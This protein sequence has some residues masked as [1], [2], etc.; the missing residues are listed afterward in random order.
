MLTFPAVF[1]ILLPL[2][3]GILSGRIPRIFQQEK[4]GSVVLISL[5]PH[6]QTKM[7]KNYPRFHF[8]PAYN[9]INDP[10]GTIYFNGS[11]HLFYQY[12][13][14]SDKWGNLHWGHTRTKDFIHYE[15]MKDMLC[16]QH[17]KGEHHC[18]SGCIGINSN[19]NPVLMYTSVQYDE[20]HNPN[21][22]K[23]VLLDKDMKTLSDERINAI[24]VDME[25][26]PSEI[27]HDW[28]D[29][30]MFNADGRFFLVLGAAV[31][32]SQVPSILLFESPDGSLVNWKY[33][34]VLQTFKPI[35]E[36]MECPNFFPLQGKWVLLGSPY[37][38]VQYQTGTFNTEKLEFKTEEAGLIDHSSQFYATNTFR[39]NRNRTILVA[40]INGF[41]SGQGWNNVIS[42]PRTL[43]LTDNREL[44]QLP[45]S[46][47]D[48][49]QGKSLLSGGK[50]KADIMLNGAMQIS[51]PALLQCR[52]TCT[53]IRSEATAEMEVLLK[54]GTREICKISIAPE[55]IV[56][57][58]IHIPSTRQNATEIDLLIDHSV[59]EIF[60]DGGRY[61]ATRT[62]EAIQ[63][64][65]TLEFKGNCL[66]KALQVHE[67][68]SLSIIEEQ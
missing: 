58:S 48:T 37:G 60:I 14:A 22:Q 40:F 41:S 6:H 18:F 61:C 44:V 55:E 11:Y 5:L 21:I 2:Q 17:E 34:K 26:L 68:K 27:R 10:N 59:M 12:N 63:N 28:R 20:K 65:E 35:I 54:A 45:I 57:D 16:P 56:F 29:P 51:D 24:T 67:V 39:D 4:G 25:G 36:L 15:V 30:Y 62:N 13:P 47:F 8:R 66:L 19:G 49:L 43:S 31:G 53:V 23:A 42:I 32:S 52:I 3:Q 9:W 33:L 38:Q 7:D 46:E 1:P 64:L 50:D